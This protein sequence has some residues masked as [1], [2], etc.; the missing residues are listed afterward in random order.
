VNQPE[1]RTTPEPEVEPEKEK[2]KEKKPKRFLMIATE[3]PDIGIST[4]YPDMARRGC[5]D[6]I[7][8]RLKD[9][10]LQEASNQTRSDALK[11]AKDSEDTYVIWMQFQV[12]RMTSSSRGGFELRYSILEPKT[13]KMIG[14]GYGY[15]QQP[16]TRV[17]LPPIGGNRPEILADWAGRDVAHQVMRRLGWGQ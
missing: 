13:G 2:E 6:E 5:L 10:S 12:D 17:P 9:V 1:L 4:Y 3:M 11:T 14:S 15:P 8:D 7:R 16:Q